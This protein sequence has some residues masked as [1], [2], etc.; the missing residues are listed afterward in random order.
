MNQLFLLGTPDLAELLG[1]SPRTVTRLRKNGD[2]KSIRVRGRVKFH[3][4][5]VA[6]YLEAL[7]RTPRT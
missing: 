4:A 6:A 5:D 3:P 1:V 7:R 2:L